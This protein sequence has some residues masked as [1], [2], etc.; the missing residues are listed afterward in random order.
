[1]NIQEQQENSTE[2]VIEDVDV[3]EKEFIEEQ[4]SEIGKII[5][6]QW[7]ADSQLLEKKCY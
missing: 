6:A 1:M 2:A 5:D 7:E 3:F 4:F